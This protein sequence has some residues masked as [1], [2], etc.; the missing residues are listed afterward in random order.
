[1]ADIIKL[2][3]DHV[4]NQIAAGEVVQ[5]PAS[6]VKELLENA[7]DAGATSIKLIVK[8]AGKT[9]IQIID[10]G[11]GMSDTDAR[12]S[13]ERHATSKITTADDLFNLNTKGFRGEALASIAA[14]AHVDLKTRPSG[15]EVG[16]HIEI[17]GSTINLQ[18]VCACPKGTSLSVKNLFFNIPARRN[19]LKS[20]NVELRH[21]I[22]EFQRVALA[23]PAISFT[24]YHNEGELFRLH[25]GNLKQRI[26]A[27][28]GGK[29]NE[30]LVPVQEETDI[31]T[32][33]GFVVKPE[34]SKKTRG[35]Q[36]FFVNDRF[37]KSPYLNHAVTAAFD[38]LLPDKARASYFLYLKVDPRTIDINIHPTKTEIKFD[39]EHALYA[40][41]RSTIKHSLGQF[42]IT[43][44]L[45]F[46][47]DSE[48][49]TPYEYK[50]KGVVT[51]KIE[52]DRTFNPFENVGVP[53]RGVQRSEFE[54]VDT[55]GWEKMYEGIQQSH[56]IASTITIEKEVST[57]DMFESGM[58]DSEEDFAFAKANKN[59]DAQQSLEA[60][61]Y[62]LTNKYIVSTIK[63]GMVV[64]DQHRAHQ[65]VLYEEFLRNIT[66]KESVS[67]QLLFPL[68][69]TYTTTE[70][71]LLEELKE[72]L[73]NTGFLFGTISGDIVEICG[74][75]TSI[76]E[77][78][79]PVVI[80]QLLS[81]LENEV[82][83]SSFSQTD[84]LA[85]SMAKSLAIR[86]GE[87]LNAR[88]REHLVNSLFACKEP[89]RSPLGKTTFITMTGEEL[90]RKF[91]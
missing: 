74:I 77:S 59:P 64:I 30:K 18:E 71:E 20:N 86:G 78:Q 60:T 26:V 84:T 72:G 76:T 16:S 61:T 44:V 28:F 68:T 41:L 51:P 34:F 85:K 6:V 40:M 79:V 87:Y 57:P 19:F 90:E 13:F 37:I 54:K 7:I 73:E 70:F 2:L 81:D 83:D 58:N 10:D 53:K 45:D 29:T 22:D 3:P 1:M 23:H 33:G 56:G 14:V 25:S 82:P 24:M 66:V 46:N 4:A 5:R 15:V 55:S 88:S 75:P 8:D 50:N 32:I 39:D 35:E 63:S 89:N 65:R 11:K 91:K 62:Q 48:L 12:M 69:L 67:Q 38:G 17:E 47:R 49:D 31:L 9:L 42:S 36:F 43:P 80:E 27:I 21:I 52:V